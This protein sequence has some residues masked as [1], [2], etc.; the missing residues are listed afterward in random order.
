MTELSLSGGQEEVVE[1]VLGD[2]SEVVLFAD[3][4]VAIRTGSVEACEQFVIV[5]EE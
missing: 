5:V 2:Q 3:A 4:A 1:L